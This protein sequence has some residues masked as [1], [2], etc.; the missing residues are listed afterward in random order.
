M[1]LTGGQIIVETLKRERVPYILGI[2]GHGI[3]SL[4]DAIREGESKGDI[5]YLQ[6]KHEQTAAH[7]ADAY[8][9]MTGRPLATISSIGPG[10]LN[11]PIGLAT[12]YVDSSA[13]IS[14]CGD[15]HVHMKGVGVLQEIERY[16]DSNFIRALEPLV[17]R[18]WRAESAE[19]LPRILNRAFAQMLKGRPGPVAVA[20]PMDVQAASAEVDLPGAA[21]ER[22]QTAGKADEE[23]IAAAISLMKS[24]RR[25]VIL[26]GGASLRTRAAARLQAMAEAWGAAV[27]TTLAG[28]SAFPEDHPLYAYHTGSKGTPVGLAIT[29]QADVILAVGTRFADE[30]TSSY[31]D[32]VSFSFPRT[33]LIHVDIESAEI[34]KNYRADVPVVGDLNAVLEQLTQAYG[35]RTERAEYFQEIARRKNDWAVLLA[36]RRRLPE[37]ELTITQMIG[38]LG[39]CLPEDT[40]IASSSGNTQAQLFQEYC[41]K[42]PGTCLTTG[43]FSTMGW[44]LPAALGAKLACPDRPV[45]ALMGDGA[46]MMTMQELSTMVQYNLPV[47]V[48]L[49]N[50]C[51]WHAIKDL[52]RDAFGE[53]CTFGNDWL[54][55]KGNLYSPDFAGVA[56]AFG[57]PAWHVERQNELR[58]AVTEA[59]ASGGPA[60][61][62]ADVSRTPPYTGGESFGW[63]DVPVPG[64]LEPQRARYEAG[65]AQER[66]SL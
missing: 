39:E 4:F 47:V 33:K 57:V 52:Q 16:Q 26:A 30:T 21:P 6:V 20:L 42:K 62:V 13:M 7:M 18:A 15:T 51:G 35:A 48:V 44:A 46:F 29:S 66:W 2:P 41:F 58:D 31:R 55:G 65:K 54:D 27:V 14:F 3:L 50:N 25:P 56:R 37:N 23:S 40:I 17:K 43:G 38:I 53:A 49:A 36:E 59:L 10:S 11:L 45:V 34:G 12:A 32:G 61:V 1:M 64:Y 5:K 19:Q 22:T 9:R 63:W 24:A 8:F 60:M 28:K